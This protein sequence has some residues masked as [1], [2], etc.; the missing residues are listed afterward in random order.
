LVGKFIAQALNDQVARRAGTE[1]Y[2]HTDSTAGLGQSA[3]NT[4]VVA[5]KGC[6]GGGQYIAAAEKHK[7]AIYS[8]FMKLT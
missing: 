1:Q 8:S 7:S 6:N 3:N 2:R 5:E 4:I